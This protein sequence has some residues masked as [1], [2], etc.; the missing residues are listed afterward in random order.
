MTIFIMDKDS[1]SSIPELRKVF[2]DLTILHSEEKE[3]KDN[4][5]S[6][7]SEMFYLKESY[8]ERVN[9]LLKNSGQT[10]E[11]YKNE[12]NEMQEAQKK[13][14]EE[15][16]V[17]FLDTKLSTY[18]KSALVFSKSILDKL[19]ILYN[20]RYYGKKKCFESKG[21]YLIKEVQ[22]NYKG[23]N[24]KEIVFL[25]EAHKEKWIDTLLSFR[26]EFTHHSK[27]PQYKNFHITTPLSHKIES[28]ADFNHPCITIRREKFNAV[29]YLDFIF[30]NLISFCSDFLRL[31]GF[32]QYHKIELTYPLI[33]GRCKT[34][35]VEKE[36]INNKIYYKLDGVKLEITNEEHSHGLIYCPNKK[37]NAFLECH[38][39]HLLKILNVQY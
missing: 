5:S 18:F 12:I 29:D 17:E 2:S 28:L 33:C 3:L 13:A 35:V 26:D 36:N 24:S 8:K 6:A 4:L 19:V 38:L 22:N 14:Q 34:T 16:E 15:H 10:F 21:S 25:I 31:S 32:N 30:D 27:L 9:N 20:F 37:C 39:G 7:I 11:H 1:S 23:N